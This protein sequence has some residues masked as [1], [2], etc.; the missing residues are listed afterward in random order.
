ML[1]CSSRPPLETTPQVRV[2]FEPVT[3][4]VRELCTDDSSHRTDY[5]NV[6][7]VRFIGSTM[8][9]NGVPSSERELLDW[10]QKK[11]PIMAEQALWVQL[12]P[13]NRPIAERALLPVVKSFPRLHLRQVDSGFMCL[14]Q[15]KGK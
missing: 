2:V 9:L 5:I 15:P 7:L 8:E 11:Y 6:P 4:P 14:T 3:D 12:S 1:S 10:A 13:E